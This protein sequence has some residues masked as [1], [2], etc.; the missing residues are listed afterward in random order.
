MIVAITSEYHFVRGPDGVYTDAS[1]PYEF[2]TRLH[3][4]FEEVVIVARVGAG[5]VGVAGA[6][7]G[8]AGSTAR[9]RRVDGPGVRV[10]AVRDFAGTAGLARGLASLAAVATRAVAG[11]DVVILRAPGVIATAAHAAAR[12]LRRPYAIEVVG[13]PWESL[14]AAV[15]A[16]QRLRGLGRRQLRAQVA[17]AAASRFVTAGYLQSRYPP[18]PGT[19]TITYSD[20]DL[21]DA[22]FA[23]P[24]PPTAPGPALALAFVGSLAQPYKALDVLIDAL[25]RTRHP[26]RVRVA[27]DGAQRPALVA[28]AAERGVADRVTFLGALPGAAVFDELRRADLFVSPSRTEGMPRALLEAMAVGLPCLA[29]PVGGVPEVLPAEA[30]VPVDDPGA[31]AAAIDALAADP[32]RRAAWAAANRDRVAH[33]RVSERQRRFTA[34]LDAVRAAAR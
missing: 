34:F 26:H 21:P 17:G 24:R 8:A 9:L 13:D 27:G 23:A 2:W 7:A 4:A 1:Y 30:H 5:A 3:A 22:L 10:A 6:G 28:R 20:L 31:L 19:F 12:L 29:T 14:G 33:Y 32:A 25:A 18:R 16:L 11:A 15:P